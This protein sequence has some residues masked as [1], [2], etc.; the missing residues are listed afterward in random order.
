MD[1][2]ENK[3]LVRNFLGYFKSGNLDAISA[4]LS[5]DLVWWSTGGDLFPMAGTK[6]K[7]ELMAAF[8]GIMS[9]FQ[10]GIEQVPVGMVAEDD[11]VAVESECHAITQDGRRYDNFI[12]F[13]FQI[14]DG[15]IVAAKE[16]V[17]TLYA[18]HV[19]ID[20]H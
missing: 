19:L 4:V 17:D 3:T 6:G 7:P 9:M 14:R 13:L 1:I 18:K 20:G 8:G 16:Y 15:Q 2:A 11:R 12:H 10:N 5:D